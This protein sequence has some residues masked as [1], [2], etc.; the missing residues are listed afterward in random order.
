MLEERVEHIL[1]HAREKGFDGT[2][3]VGVGFCAGVR[4]AHFMA[5]QFEERGEVATALTGS[6]TLEHRQEVYARLQDPCDDLEW[7]FVADLLN[8]GV[9]IPRINTLLFLRPTQSATVFLQQL[10]RGL[11]LS[12]DCEVLTVLDFVG[13]HRNAWAA[14]D[15]MHDAG[16]SRNTSTRDDVQVTPP[17]YC[18]I[19]LDDKTLEVLR[20]V[21][22]FTR[23][24]KDRCSDAYRQLKEE[25]GR[26]PY[27]IDLLARVDVPD[28]GTF[29]GAFGAWIE[30]RKE[31]GDVVRWEKDL[32]KNLGAYELLRRA[33]LDWQQQRVYAYALLWGLCDEPDDPEAGYERFFERFPRWKDEHAPVTNTKAWTTLAK[34]LGDVLDEER[35]AD[36][37][38]E[39]FP[40]TETMKDEVERR[41]RYTLERDYRT[42]HGGVL[43]TPDA[44]TVHR[45]YDR[46]VIINHFGLQYDP[47]KH[48]KGVLEFRDEDGVLEHIVMITKI[49]AI[50]IT[51]EDAIALVNGYRAQLDGQGLSR[52][53][54]SE[55][56]ADKII[57]RYA[58]MASA[59][60][61]ASG[62]TA[63]VP[64]IGTAVAATGGALADVAA[65][66][67]LQV[68]IRVPRGPRARLYEDMLV[69]RRLA[70]DTRQSEPGPPDHGGARAAHPVARR[71]APGEDRHHEGA[72]F[73]VQGA[74]P[75]T[76]GGGQRRGGRPLSR[77]TTRARGSARRR[78]GRRRSVGRR[79]ATC[80][81]PMTSEPTYIRGMP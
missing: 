52:S 2:K 50:A 80:G 79:R 1:H 21:Q 35:L 63:I 30:C 16:A 10:G 55:A 24:K 54:Q 40:D 36:G 65:S 31:H 57:T 34:K 64:G 42:R 77:G 74:R 6:Y 72:G 39:A 7:L 78:A 62:L 81:P 13:R 12:D 61:G 43:T 20:N 47:A 66:M 49:E 59:V 67:K 75:R 53:Q 37:I 15:A 23:K 51:P 33:E 4:H 56:I 28:L 41:I 60:G 27:P 70:L 46:P 8:E 29:R 44:L 69:G 76:R 22:R 48:N 9:D 3:R 68:D 14:L 45:K 58:R 11:R 38:I 17:P 5:E 18:E 73:S 71:R 26:A 19:V 32:S 25:L